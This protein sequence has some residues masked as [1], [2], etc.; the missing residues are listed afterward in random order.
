MEK[1]LTKNIP[2]AARSLDLTGLRAR[3][4]YQGL[5]KALH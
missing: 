5:R 2:A 4:R 1:P 3:G